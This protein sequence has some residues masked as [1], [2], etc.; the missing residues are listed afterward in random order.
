MRTD[1]EP[2]PTQKDLSY[3]DID[4]AD[5]GGLT[6]A[7]LDPDSDRPSEGREETPPRHDGPAEGPDIG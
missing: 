2:Q 1:P 5:V 7:D 3:P 6:L 4:D